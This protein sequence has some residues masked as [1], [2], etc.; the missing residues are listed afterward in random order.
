MKRLTGHVSLFIATIALLAPLPA[1][2]QGT[3]KPDHNIEIVV[4]ATTGAG[5][6]KAARMMQGM[7]QKKNA[8][9]VPSIVSNKPGGGGA[10]S[11][12]YL[13]QKQG[14]AHT[15]L[16]TSY[17]IVTN[18]ITGKSKLTYS[19][20]TPIGLLISEHIT[21]CVKR[22]SHYKT[23]A[24]AV[25]ALKKDPRSISVGLSS[26]LGGA[27]H[28]ALGLLMKAAGVDVHKMRIVVFNSGGESLTSLLGGHVDMMVASTSAVATQA[29]AGALRPLAVSASQRMTGPLATIPTTVESG[30]KVVADNWRIV[31]APK[32]LTGA[33][34]AYWDGTLKALTSSEEWRTELEKGSLSNNYLN[35]ADTRKYLDAEYADIRDI[36]IE[37]G[38]TKTASKP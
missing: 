11:W 12:A 38:L 36:L 10:V 3:W 1:K 8:L 37:L 19:D 34:I 29:A 17:N 35:S 28:I 18:H 9:N 6:D 21:Y 14:D 2:A 4:G 7:W 30:Y 13:G 16:V 31:I 25:D 24:E 5:T 33:Q 23:L 15:L 26:S 27:N 32:N 22:D 20:F